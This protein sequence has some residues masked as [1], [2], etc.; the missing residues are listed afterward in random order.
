[1]KI[2][3]RN[4]AFLLFCYSLFPV[5]IC[6]IMDNLVEVEEL[7]MHSP[8]NE[9]RVGGA[10]LLQF[11]QV[12]DLLSSQYDPTC[13]LL[14]LTRMAFSTGLSETSARYPPPPAPASFHA[15]ARSL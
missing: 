8:T 6:H 7:Y 11:L 13:L 1:M 12:Y 15:S 2:A 3:T 4:L 5:L 14:I 9:G 10:C